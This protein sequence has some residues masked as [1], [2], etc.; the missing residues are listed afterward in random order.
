MVAR[1]RFLL[2]LRG[3][4]EYASDG[5]DLHARLISNAALTTS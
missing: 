3:I 5:G 2:A 1:S 4:F